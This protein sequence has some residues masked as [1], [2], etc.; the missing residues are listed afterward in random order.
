MMDALFVYEQVILAATVLMPSVMGVMNLATLPRT[1]PTRFLYQEC[2]ATMADL[3]QGINKPT[4]KGTD[5]TLFMVLDIKDISAGHS[6]TPILTMTE[7]A[8]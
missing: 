8:V 6:P 3:I 5:H 4:A 1:A 7:E 2:H